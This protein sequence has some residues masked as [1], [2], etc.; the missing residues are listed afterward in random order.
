MKKL[1]RAGE[2][3]SARVGRMRMVFVDSLKELLGLAPD[4]AQS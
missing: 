2:V 4:G 3:K 1:I